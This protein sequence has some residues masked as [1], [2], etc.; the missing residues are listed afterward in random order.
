[1]LGK[2]LTKAQD[3]GRRFKFVRGRRIE[4]AAALLRASGVDDEE[5][6]KQTAEDLLLNVFDAFYAAAAAG[7]LP[8]L[9]PRD[10]DELRIDFSKLAVRRPT[11]FLHRPRLARRHVNALLL[12]EFFR[13]T[14]A[15]PDKTGAMNAYEK[16]GSFCG[17]NTAA[18]WETGKGKPASNPPTPWRRDGKALPDWA[19]AGDTD[20]PLGRL[21]PRYLRLLAEQPEA[22]VAIAVKAQ[23]HTLV[24]GTPL[25][26][27]LA[28]WPSLVRRTADDFELALKKWDHAYTSGM[29]DWE[30]EDGNRSRANALRYELDSLARWTVIAYLGDRQFLPSFGF[31]I[32]VLKLHVR[33]ADTRG[34]GTVQEKNRFSLERGGLLGV[35]EYAPGCH[36]LAGGRVVKSRGLRK[37]WHGGDEN[38]PFG[39]SLH[40]ATCS[41][42][43]FA[44]SL[45]R[46]TG[47]SECEADLQHAPRHAVLVEHGFSTAGWDPPLLELDPRELAGRVQTGSDGR[48]QLVIWD[49]AAG[50]AGHVFELATRSH[51]WLDRTRDLLFVDDAHQRTCHTACL[52]C[53][54]DFHVQHLIDRNE[55]SRPD[56]LILLEQILARQGV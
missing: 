28:N 16:M 38:T 1:M 2:F 20:E 15:Q 13:S 51:D 33:E 25:T 8:W 45:S 17:V 19:G 32:N 4:F 52:R 48:Q 30:G 18:L 3:D 24:H 43:H 40:Y 36:V 26:S 50:G 37:N 55:I 12:G 29:R 47:C 31:P 23:I 44:Q 39:R 41:A 35:R 14:Q 56:G 9:D 53:I 10:G 6:L 34:G 42:G 5:N 46:L 11:V 54:L 22:P 21:F 27:E 7:V 49:S